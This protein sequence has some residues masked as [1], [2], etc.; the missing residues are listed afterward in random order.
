MSEHSQDKQ[1]PTLDYAAASV[2]P[3]G[4]AKGIIIAARI[5]AA[6]LSVLIVWIAYQI[7]IERGFRGG[8]LLAE[9]LLLA[10]SV[11]CFLVAIGVISERTGR[12]L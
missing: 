4:K 9:G 5:I 3:S 12:K 7:F 11:V 2:K 1:Q 10:L 6:L 8:G